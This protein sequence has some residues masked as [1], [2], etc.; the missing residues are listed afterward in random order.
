[1]LKSCAHTPMVCS[2]CRYKDERATIY[3]H[4]CTRELIKK[5]KKIKAA[6]HTF[7]SERS[8]LS[9]KSGHPL[10]LSFCEADICCRFCCTDISEGRE[11][12][13]CGVGGCNLYLCQHCALLKPITCDKKHPLTKNNQN[14]ITAYNG[15]YYGLDGRYGC[16]NCKRAFS[17]GRVTCSSGSCI[18]DLCSECALC[19]NGHILRM[20][21][22]QGQCSKC[23]VK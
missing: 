5:L 6:T 13:T 17:L 2:V 16:H 1:M 9:C 22:Q 12:F 14:K 8:D 4:D 20:K 18:F 3:N 10:G 7:T 21:G 11:Y 23:K 15:G 19:P